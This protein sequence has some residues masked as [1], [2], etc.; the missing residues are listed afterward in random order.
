MNGYHVLL[1]SLQR[2]SL[3]NCQTFTESVAA[4]RTQSPFC[5]SAADYTKVVKQAED[6]LVPTE[7]KTSP[8]VLLGSSLRLPVLVLLATKGCDS[9]RL[10]TC[11]G[12]SKQPSCSML[13]SV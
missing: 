3:H 9:D 11:L 10:Y 1:F 4:P 5:P 12:S 13:G 6:K 2:L 7:D 8:S